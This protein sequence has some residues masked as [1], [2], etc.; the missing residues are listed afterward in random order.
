MLSYL[1][2]MLSA[3]RLLA[4]PLAAFLILHFH[5][6]AA[7]AVFV[8]AGASDAADGFI[9][10]RWGVVSRSGAWLD[11]AADKLLMLA[12]FVA[13]WRIGAAP[14]WLTVLVI[15]RDIALAAGTILVKSLS[16]PLR[17]APILLGKASTA[18][19]VFYIGFLLLAAFNLDAPRLEMAAAIITAIFTVLSLL[20]YTHIL[21]RVLAPGR[22]TA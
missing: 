5:D 22:R 17:V 14:L 3:L 12:C 20:G 4:A 13:L 9:A 11:P 16:L 15:G 2:N 7:L 1:P 6:S 10:R 8:L 19:Q 18:L 21:L